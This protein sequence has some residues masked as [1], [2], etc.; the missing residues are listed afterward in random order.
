MRLGVM[1]TNHVTIVGKIVEKNDKSVVL[2]D[3]V[4]LFPFPVVQQAGAALGMIGVRL[5][6]VPVKHGLM[7]ELTE[8]SDYY[9]TYV[10][11]AIRTPARTL[12]TPPTKPEEPKKKFHMEI[13]D[14]VH[15]EG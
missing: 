4:Q 7:V 3:A 12:P 14:A 6:E 9:R 15:K 2:K 5:G 11:T 13:K 1:F 10:D 8:D